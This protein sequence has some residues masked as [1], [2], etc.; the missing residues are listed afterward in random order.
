MR[1]GLRCLS[2]L[3]RSAGKVIRR[4]ERAEPGDLIHI[5]HQ[6]SKQNTLLKADGKFT[7]KRTQRVLEPAG[8]PVPGLQLLTSS[9]KQITA[10]WFT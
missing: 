3:D 8:D 1:N 4:Y 9:N 5:G 6:K 10:A 2:G 7:A